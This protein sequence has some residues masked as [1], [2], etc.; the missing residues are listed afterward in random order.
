MKHPG[1][2]N[3]KDGFENTADEFHAEAFDI[4]E[5]QNPF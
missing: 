4:P 3:G 1:H 2:E 5:I